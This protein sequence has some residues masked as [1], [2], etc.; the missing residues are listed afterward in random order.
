MQRFYV[1]VNT[2]LRR[3]GPKIKCTPLLTVNLLES[4][5]D[6]LQQRLCFIRCAHA[7]FGLRLGVHRQNCHDH[8]ALSCARVS[9]LIHSMIHGSMHPWIN[10]Q[11]SSTHQPSIYNHQLANH[12]LPIYQTS[13][14]NHQ[15]TTVNRQSPILDRQSPPRNHQSYKQSSSHQPSRAVIN[16]Q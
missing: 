1:I 7:S 10:R 13:V 12:R 16:H 6:S 2:V 15:A 11:P 5:E 8:A 14:I 4:Q 3:L 9:T